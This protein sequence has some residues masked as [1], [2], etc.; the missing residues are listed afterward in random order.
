MNQKK[1]IFDLKFNHDEVYWQ[2]QEKLP[3]TKEMQKFIN[4]VNSSGRNSEFKTKSNLN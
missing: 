3:L 1:D 4:E 2:N